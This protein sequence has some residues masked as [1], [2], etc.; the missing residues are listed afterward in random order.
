MLLDENAPRTA[1][2]QLLMTEAEGEASITPEDREAAKALKLERDEAAAEAKAAAEAA[3]A[4][5]AAEAA[6]AA[7]E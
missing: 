3:A 7:E 6:A 2:L 4:E 1:R 5:A